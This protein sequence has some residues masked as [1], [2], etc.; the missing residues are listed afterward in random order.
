MC[1]DEYFHLNIFTL[2]LTMEA[3]TTEISKRK[4][5]PGSLQSI[6]WMFVLCDITLNPDDCNDC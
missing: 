3:S 6:S 1:L 4:L 5:P 2:L